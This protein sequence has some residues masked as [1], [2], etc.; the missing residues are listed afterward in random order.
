LDY[1]D[2]EKFDLIIFSLVLDHVDRFESYLFKASE[3]L[4]DL[5]RVVCILPS[6][7]KD[8]CAHRNDTGTTLQNYFYEGRQKKARYDENGKKFCEVVSF[9]RTLSTYLNAFSNV[10]LRLVHM[11]EPRHPDRTHAG[12]HI[13]YFTVLEY[14]K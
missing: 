14:R 11:A 9:K 3:M 1:H 2:G 10:G 6:P 4:G 12:H 5:G 8:S 13:P 7:L